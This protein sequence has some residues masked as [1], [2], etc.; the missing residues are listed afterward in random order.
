MLSKRLV[1]GFCI[2][3]FIGI[4]I[5]LIQS[6]KTKYSKIFTKVHFKIKCL[7]MVLYII[8]MAYNIIMLKY[9]FIM[10]LK[11]LRN[12]FIKK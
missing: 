3:P 5:S 2:K 1:F 4:I 6:F 10:K 12:Y 7:N 9:I 8:L 11:I